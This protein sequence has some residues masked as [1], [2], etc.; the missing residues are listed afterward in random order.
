MRLIDADALMKALVRK[1]PFSNDARVVIAE[2]MEE[3]RHSPTV[4]QWIPVSERM[5]EENGRYLVTRGLNA[6]ESLWNRIY[7]INYS[8]LMGT[9]KEK[10]WWSGNVGKS[11]FETYDDVKAWCKLPEPYKESEE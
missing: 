9:K 3:V 6:C 7:L 8:D 4:S 5:P 1:E 2:C 11:D 10:I